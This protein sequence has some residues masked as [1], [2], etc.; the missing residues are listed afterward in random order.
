LQTKVPTKSWT[1]SIPSKVMEIVEIYKERK[2]EFVNYKKEK[3]SK[4]DI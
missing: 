1:L 3:L 2:K 4:R